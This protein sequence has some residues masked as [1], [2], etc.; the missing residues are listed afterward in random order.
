M[1]DEYLIKYYKP[2]LTVN[3]NKYVSLLNAGNVNNIKILSKMP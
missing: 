2:Y 3:G 1:R